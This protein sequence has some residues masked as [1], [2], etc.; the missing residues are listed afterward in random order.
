MADVNDNSPVF[1]G[2]PYTVNISEAVMVGSDITDDILA[3]DDDQPGPFSSVVYSIPSSSPFS[4]FVSMTNP[5]QGRIVLSKS[6]DYESLQSFQVRLIAKDQGSPPRESETTITINVLDA[7][8]Q[9]PVFHYDRYVTVTVVEMLAK[10]QE[11]RGS[12][13][14]YC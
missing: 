9:N 5:L 8:D 14:P 11:E 10:T 3:V 12:L 13:S 7:D 2:A 4:D 1:I 6:L